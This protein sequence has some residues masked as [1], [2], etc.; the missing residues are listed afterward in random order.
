MKKLLLVLILCLIFTGCQLPVEAEPVIITETI[1]ETVVE[2]V[3][4]T[5]TVEDNAKIE[6]LESELED[7]RNLVNDLNSLL[8]NVYY[9]YAENE[10]WILDGFTAFSIEY[11]DKYYL[12]T[13]GHCVENEDGKFYNHRFKA[14]FSNDWIYPELIDYKN[15]IYYDYSIFKSNKI[16]S[17]FRISTSHKD[18]T[19]F[20]L[21]STDNKLN[22]IKNHTEVPLM[23][24]G[25]SGSPLVD[26]NGNVVGITNMTLG[27]FKISYVLEAI[28]NMK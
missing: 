19:L 8:S 7:Y 18:K 11:K 28:D 10:N 13:A 27:F 25:E 16:S 17:G 15:D 24:A 5:V 21:G 1:T 20:V 4:E 23:H 3:V 9:G 2:T 26:L 14:N 6:Q 12:I 22:I